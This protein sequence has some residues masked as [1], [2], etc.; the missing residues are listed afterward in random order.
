MYTT[1]ITVSCGFRGAWGSI[2]N[3]Y[4]LVYYSSLI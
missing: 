2:Q 4:F 1:L 3:E